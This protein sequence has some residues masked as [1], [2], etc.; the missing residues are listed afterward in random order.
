MKISH[1]IN[2]VIELLDKYQQIRDKTK[3]QIKTEYKKIQKKI[4]A[5]IIQGLLY[6][7]AISLIIAGIIIF[8]TRFFSLELVFLGIGLILIYIATLLK[9]YYQK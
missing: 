2:N 3:K 8:L 6:C 1:L 7:L 9:F 4:I 5:S